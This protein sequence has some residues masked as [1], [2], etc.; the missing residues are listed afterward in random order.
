M[1]RFQLGKEADWGKEAKRSNKRRMLVKTAQFS[2]LSE[3]QLPTFPSLEFPSEQ[4]YK[5]GKYSACKKKNKAMK[6]I[7]GIVFIGPVFKKK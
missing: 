3:E 6:C 5:K 2:N 7:F 4:K 1:L